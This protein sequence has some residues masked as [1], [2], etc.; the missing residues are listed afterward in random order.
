MERSE[1]SK[2]ECPKSGGHG[3]NKKSCPCKAKYPKYPKYVIDDQN[4]SILKVSLV[5][6]KDP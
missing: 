6:K 5:E 2:C 3:R 1:I 4:R